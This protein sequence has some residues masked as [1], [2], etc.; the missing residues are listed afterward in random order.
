MVATPRV[1]SVSR[2][3]T[4][5]A[6]PHYKVSSTLYIIAANCSGKTG[7]ASDSKKKNSKFKKKIGLILLSNKAPESL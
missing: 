2:M 1:N 5:T 3:T 4:N 7:V 6:G